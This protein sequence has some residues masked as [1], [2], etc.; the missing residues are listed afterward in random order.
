MALQ[1]HVAKVFEDLSRRY[2]HA[3]PSQYRTITF[4]E[5]IGCSTDQLCQY[6]ERKFSN[7]DI[8]WDNYGEYWTIIH[9]T[10]ISAFD[11]ADI[12]QRKACFHH[13]NLCIYIKDLPDI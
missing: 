7:E 9:V 12:G 5:L 3:V 1:P 6:I 2:R 10:P 4:S 8:N 11:V 13:T